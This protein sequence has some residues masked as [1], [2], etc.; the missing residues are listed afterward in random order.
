MD[1]KKIIQERGW[2]I[3]QVAEQMTNKKGEKGISQSALSQLINGNPTID[4]LQEIASIIGVSLSV[5]VGGGNFVICPYCGNKIN[6]E[7]KK[8]E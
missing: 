5:L 3:S 2:T 8:P 4:K 1:I 7:L 6:V